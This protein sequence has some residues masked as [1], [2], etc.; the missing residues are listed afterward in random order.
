MLVSCLAKASTRSWPPAYK[1][2]PACDGPNTAK[3]RRDTEF[4]FERARLLYDPPRSQK[5]AATTTPHPHEM[6][7]TR[8]QLTL[9]AFDY[10]VLGRSPLKE[11]R[12]ARRTTHASHLSETQG[13]G[14]QEEN[15][16]DEGIDPKHPK[17]K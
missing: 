2:Q 11:A 15:E 16:G 7:K 8:S 10:D 12:T 5:E 13:A 1:R 3:H 9:P 17:N 14:G 4:E 6:I